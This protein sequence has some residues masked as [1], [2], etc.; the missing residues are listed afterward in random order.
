MTNGELARAGYEAAARGELDRIAA[1]LAPDVKWHAGD[2]TAVGTC[3]NREQA[4]QFMRQ[5]VRRGGVGELVDVVDAGER[6]VVIMRR[7][8]EGP[9]PSLVANVSRFVDGR[10]VEM[11]HYPKAADALAAVGAA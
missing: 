3:Q 8:A 9:E 4:L 6:V 2:P 5:A 7:P 1:L 11:V 10:V